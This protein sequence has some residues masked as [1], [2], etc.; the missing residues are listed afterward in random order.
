[1]TPVA[2]H[3]ITYLGRKVCL[4]HAQLLLKHNVGLDR[5]ELGGFNIFRYLQRVG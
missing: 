4:G 2:A 3:Q 1:M 5:I